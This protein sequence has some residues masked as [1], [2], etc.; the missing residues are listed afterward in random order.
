MSPL[1]DNAVNAT[2]SVQGLPVPPLVLHGDRDAA[3]T[4]SVAF[5]S[6][7][8]QL[9]G[10][11]HDES[12]QAWKLEDGHQVGTL[13]EEEGQ[14][15]AVTASSDG[16]WVATEQ[17]NTLTIWNAKTDGKVV[18]LKVQVKLVTRPSLLPDCKR[19][20]A[21]CQDGYTKFF[22]SQ[23]GSPPRERKRR[24]RL[25]H[26]IAVSPNAKFIAAGSWDHQVRVSDTATY[27]QIDP[28]LHHD[29]QVDYVPPR[30]IHLDGGRCDEEVRTWSVKDIIPS[31][32]G[33]THAAC[34]GFP[35]VY[36]IIVNSWI[37]QPPALSF[38]VSTH[39]PDIRLQ[40][41]HPANGDLQ[42]VPLVCTP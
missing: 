19:L 16:Q 40:Q 3:Q 28:N 34:P 30:D 4:H 33:N 17:G 10:G 13:I 18:E 8:K 39:L 21:G 35:P 24:R 36:P 9:I 38:H 29:D 2:W 20:V 1:N 32:L 26:S 25:V 27:T 37:W 31:S 15:Y 23:T 22:D 14:V 12:A 7:G 11:S 42:P 6:D 5:L 41:V